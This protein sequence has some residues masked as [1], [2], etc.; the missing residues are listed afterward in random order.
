MRRRVGL[1]LAVG[2]A[3]AVTA[4]GSR[5]AGRALVGRT[6]ARL[7]TTANPPPYHASDRALALHESLWIAD[8]HANSLLWGPRARGALDARSRGPPAP[9]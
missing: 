2:A 1:A 8:L 5:I 3:G 6:E 4:F 7:C 9:S